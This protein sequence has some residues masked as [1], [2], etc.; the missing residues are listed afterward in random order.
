MSENLERARKIMHCWQIAPQSHQ[1]QKQAKRQ[2]QKPGEIIVSIHELRE[3]FLQETNNSL[4]E[5][6]EGLRYLQDNDILV[7]VRDDDLLVN[8]S[9]LHELMHHNSE[10]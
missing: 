2:Y 1:K 4:K 8:Q 7:R 5:F 10:T 3:P 6:S 9:L